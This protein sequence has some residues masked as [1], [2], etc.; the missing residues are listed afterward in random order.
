MPF[1]GW[2]IVMDAAVMAPVESA[3]PR[4]TTQRPTLTSL[5]AA[6]VW[7][8]QVVLPLVV[9]ATVVA[10][11]EPGRTD[12]TEK[13]VPETWVTWPKAPPKPARPPPGRPAYPRMP[14]H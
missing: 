10:L 9:T 1:T 3:L 13:L 7:R 2:L 12:F 6:V 11:L 8:A 14:R 5:A 4:L